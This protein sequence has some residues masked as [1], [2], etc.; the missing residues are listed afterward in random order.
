MI[1]ALFSSIL[2]MAFTIFPS[3]SFAH[4][5]EEARVEIEIESNA[6][7][8]AGKVEFVFDLVDNSQKK[9]LTDADLAIDMEKKLHFIAYDAALLEF[10]H[11]HP[12]FKADGKW[13][14][15]LDFTKTGQYFLWASGKIAIDSADFAASAKLSVINGEIENPTPATLVESR[16][17]HDGNSVVTVSNTKLVAGQMA[18]LNVT[19]SRLDG[20]APQISPYLGALAHVTIVTDDADSMIHAHPMATGQPNKVMLHTTFPSEGLYRVW[21][22]FIDGGVLKRVALVVNVIK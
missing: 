7:V 1:K 2:L 13:H 22:E 20:T 16:S 21:L 17:G 5:G 6:T 11:V 18:M 15:D 3:K 19:F 10:Q 4:N 12:E 14:V 9:P 8:S